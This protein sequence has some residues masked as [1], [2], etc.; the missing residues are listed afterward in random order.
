M[1]REASAN[2]AGLEPGEGPSRPKTPSGQDQGALTSGMQ[3]LQEGAY[4][5]DRDYRVGSPHLRHWSLH[6]SLVSLLRS[7]VRR[8]TAAGLP[9]DALEMGAGHGGFTEP[10]L[11]MGWSVTAT[12]MSRPSIDRLKELFGM[13]ER[14]SACFDPD[15]SLDAV[16]SRRYALIMAVS[17]L[18][19][20]PDY[21]AL[22]EHAVTQ[23]LLPGGAFVSLQDP[24]W[25]P[26]VPAATRRVERA[27]YLSWRVL[28]G[29][30]REGAATL[31]RRLRGVYNEL[32]PGDMV[33]YH[34]V[35]QGVDQD[36]LVRT[37]TGRF[38]RCS[39]SRY[40]STPAAPWQ[41]LG[42]ALGLRNTFALVAEGYS[43][44]RE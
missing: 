24:L 5:S 31:G 6:T 25:Y 43:P 38:E 12:E 14:F 3:E 19:H 13:N 9:A 41:R 4:G 32:K 30:Y 42:T 20:V 28:R 16:G 34:V 18:H 37:L 44:D 39:L 8:L 23:Y 17:V 7:V 1:S 2:S 15:G 33:E 35:R 10:M 40:W 26:S 36:A 29:D 11:A 21:V 22:V 27:A